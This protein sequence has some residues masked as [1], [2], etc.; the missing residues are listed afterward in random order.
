MAESLG[1]DNKRFKMLKAMGFQE[2]E[3]HGAGGQ[4][5]KGPNA[6]RQNRIRLDQDLRNLGKANEQIEWEGFTFFPQENLLG[7]L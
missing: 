4:G 5:R 1:P 2:G 3:G 7:I 6:Q